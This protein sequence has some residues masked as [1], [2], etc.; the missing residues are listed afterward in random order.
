[1]KFAVTSW[2]LKK[3]PLLKFQWTLHEIYV[4]V[5]GLPLLPSAKYKGSFI[6]IFIYF[7]HE[8]FITPW[9]T[10]MWG[11]RSGLCCDTISLTGTSGIHTVPGVSSVCGVKAWEHAQGGASVS[12]SCFEAQLFSTGSKS[13]SSIQLA[14]SLSESISFQ[15]KPCLLSPGSMSLAVWVSQGCCN[16]V[17]QTGWLRTTKMYCL[18]VQEARSPKLRCQQGHLAPS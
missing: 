17:L 4:L 2:S 11:D 8:V 1:M 7:S 3:M 16:K 5:W 9:M 6:Q 12:C 15:P 13:F 14:I 10:W 18:T